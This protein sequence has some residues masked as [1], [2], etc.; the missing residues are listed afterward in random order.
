MRVSFKPT[1]TIGKEQN[2]VTLDGILIVVIC[3]Y[4]A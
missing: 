1:A 3:I 4:F 2:T